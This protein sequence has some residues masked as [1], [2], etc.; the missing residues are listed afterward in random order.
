MPLVA[1]A[2]TSTMLVMEGAAGRLLVSVPATGVLFM[3][4]QMFEAWTI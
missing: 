4:P 1:Q 3:M 2:F